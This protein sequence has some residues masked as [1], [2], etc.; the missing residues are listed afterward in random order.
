MKSTD[1][2]FFSTF[3]LNIPVMLKNTL[4]FLLLIFAFTTKAQVHMTAVEPIEVTA[5]VVGILEGNS[6]LAVVYIMKVDSTNKYALEANTEILTRFY[7]D[8]KPTKG[9]PVLPGT[10]KGDVIRAQLAGQHDNISGQMNY[11]IFKYSVLPATTIE[12]PSAEGGAP[13]HK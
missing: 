4:P 3:D 2:F 7:F 9:D 1:Y 12:I 5:R 8:T 13:P 10:K 11:V 6:Q